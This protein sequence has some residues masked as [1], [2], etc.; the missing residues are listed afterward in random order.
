G[1][2]DPNSASLSLVNEA[3]YLLVNT[4]SIFHLSQQIPLREGTDPADD[5]HGD[6]MTRRFRA[7]LVIDSKIP[8]QE[9]EWN[10][11]FIGCL[12]FKVS[13]K[14]TRCQI[15]CINQTTGEKKKEIFQTLA[16]NREGKVTFGMYL[17]NS[18]CSS[19][20]SL[21]TVGSEIYY[22]TAETKED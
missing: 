11:L 5:L 4:A 9:E 18:S 6:Q 12:H 8:F 3:Q 7:N 15:I 10:E 20:P 2:V 19:Y 13:G 17:L 14:C 1:L 21:L 22:T 16:S